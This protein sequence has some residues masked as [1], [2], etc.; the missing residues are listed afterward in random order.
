MSA[1]SVPTPSGGDERQREGVAEARVC[2]LLVERGRLKE[3]DLGRARRLHAEAPEGTLTS[4]LARLGLV[5]ERD[6]A[7]TWCELLDVPFMEA[8]QAPELPPEGVDVSPRFLRQ[9]HVVPVDAGDGR[10]GEIELAL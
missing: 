9:M 3:A 8:R 10:V 4:L 7:D 6:L 1:V 2:A 5:S